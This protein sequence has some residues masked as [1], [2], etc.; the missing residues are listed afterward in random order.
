MVS[1]EHRELLSVSDAQARLEELVDRLTENP[2]TTVYIA[3]PENEGTA[4]LVDASHYQ[5]L[6]LRAQVADALGAAERRNTT[7]G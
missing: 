6:L 5:L 2:G 3:S 4:V 1:A 7:S